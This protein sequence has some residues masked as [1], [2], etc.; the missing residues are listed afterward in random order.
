MKCD[1]NSK[2]TIDMM[3]IGGLGEPG[4][5]IDDFLSAPD[6]LVEFAAQASDW[7]DLAPGGYP[8]RRAALPGDYARKLL[9]RLDAPIRT[10][11]LKEPSKLDRFDCSFSMVTQAPKE[12]QAQQQIP[13]ID[14]ARSNRVAILHYLCDAQFGG[15]AFFRQTS[16]ELEQIG[17]EERP[18]YLAARKKDVEALGET[19]QYPDAQTTGYAQTAKIE[20]RFN[21]VIAYRSFTLH[22]GVI[23]RPELLSAD[24]KFGRLTANFFVDYASVGP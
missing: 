2:L 14:I 4:L 20:A 17:P 7:H 22:S 18:Q 21:R 16:T 8:G 19:G 15:T 23:D 12:L 11:L 10:K 6:Q 1:V 24:P 5:I 3:R 9:Q 13:H